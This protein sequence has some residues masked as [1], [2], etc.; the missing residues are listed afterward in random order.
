MIEDIYIGNQ[1][2]FSSPSIMAPFEYAIENGFKAFEWFPDK[3]DWGA[4]FNALDIDKDLRKII[5]DK[6]LANTIHLSVHADCLCNPLLEHTHNQFFNCIELAKD[7]GAL[8]IN[9]HLFIEEGIK[10]Y[11]DSLIP[12]IIKT[13]QLG[14]KLSI[15]NTPKTTPQDFNALFNAMRNNRRINTSHIGMCLDIG[16]ANL[17]YTTNNNYLGFIDQLDKSLPIIHIHMHENYGDND[18]HLPVFTGP[19]GSNPTGIIEV[20]RHLKNR[21]FRGAIILE[22]WPDDRAILR[23]SRDR[24][25]E[26]LGGI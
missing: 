19:A 3:K 1:S 7:I 16:H 8:L 11:L 10:R 12:F 9:I 26:I 6:S 15:E 21:Q 14:I 22:Q 23:F 18:T 4:G 5:K 2:A 13:S 20:L 24:L 17:C 25:N